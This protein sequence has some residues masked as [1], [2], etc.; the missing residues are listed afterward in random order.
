MKAT[1]FFSSLRA[2]RHR[3]YLF[4]D[5]A[6][7]VIKDAESDTATPQML[8]QKHGVYDFFEYVQEAVLDELR[9]SDRLDNVDVL[10]PLEFDEGTY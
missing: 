9:I 1:R 5:V 10:V 7:N 4:L 8:A 2:W 3:V 6:L